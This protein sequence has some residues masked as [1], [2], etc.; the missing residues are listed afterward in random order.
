MPFAGRD[1]RSMTT[2]G[3]SITEMTIKIYDLHTFLCIYSLHCL[4]VARYA[5]VMSFAVQ[6]YAETPDV[7][8]KFLYSNK[9]PFWHHTTHSIYPQIAQSQLHMCTLYRCVYNHHT[10]LQICEAIKTLF[11]L[12][13]RQHIRTMIKS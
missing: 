11:L 4:F 1:K 2:S 7:E 6:F 12:I 13:S 5:N 3:T 9:P 8:C 10:F